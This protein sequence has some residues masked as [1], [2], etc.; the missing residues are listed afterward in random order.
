MKNLSEK[1]VYGVYYRK[2][3]EAEDR[4]AQSIPDQIKETDAIAQKEGLQISKRFPGESQS[5]FTI[6]RPIFADLVKNIMAKKINAILVWHANRLA[7]NPVDAGMIIHLMDEGNLRLIQTPNKTYSN[8]ASDK[9]MLQLEFGMSKKDSDDKSEVVKRALIGRAERG[10]PN[11][12]APIGYIND[13]TK[14][15]G[16]RDWFKDPIRHPLVKKLLQVMLTGRYSV[17][18]L[19]TYAR[20]ELELTTLQRKKEGGNPIALSYLYRLLKNPIYAG[21]FFQKST[22]KEV[23]YKL[24]DIKSMI[25]EDEYW[26]IQG[27][28]GIRG[29]QRVT[30]QKSVYKYFTKC[31][32]CGGNL[33]TDFK[34]QLICSSCK[35]KFSYPNRSA[36]PD[37]G[38]AINKMESPTYLNY[39]FYYCI[40]NKKHRTRCPGSSIEERKLEAQL[41]L[42]MDQK[43]VISKELSQWCIK[44]VS[45][46]KDEAL[47]DGI[48]LRRNFEQKKKTNEDKLERLT[49]LRISKDCSIEDNNRFDKLQKELREELSL[50]EIKMSN[51]NIDW[52]SEAKIDFDLMSEISL[53]IRTGNIEQKKDVLFAFGTNLKI[54]DK[55]LNVT[56]KKSIEAF[57]KFLLRARIENKAFEPGKTLADKDKT[58]VFASVCPT[59]HGWRESNPRYWFWRPT[60]CH[61]TT[62]ARLT[63]IL[64]LQFIK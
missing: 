49:I 11:G 46:L 58:E 1:I 47:E 20:D 59:L 32:T 27:M 16:N 52:L 25:S 34:F 10:M 28:I 60:Y 39:T 53:L 9:F 62:P 21:F 15:Q 57:K 19:H 54:L 56:N 50:L 12:L 4:Q 13:K 8:T 41:L 45:K 64:N 42:D 48:N 33:S 51:T 5:A 7:R 6:G 44:N 29:A 43:L 3:S 26:K 36:C 18:E 30:H 2:S 31:G 23:R 17:R 37:C 40:N 63:L 61:Y 38:L 14:E 22:G 35:H 24:K 55:K